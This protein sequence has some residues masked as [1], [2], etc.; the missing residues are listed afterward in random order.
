MSCSFT[1]SLAAT[2]SE[3]ITSNKFLS[4]SFSA[5]LAFALLTLSTSPLEGQI[6]YEEYFSEPNKGVE[7]PSGTFVPPTNLQWTISGDV[8]DLNNSSDYFKTVNGEL[9]ARDTEGDGSLC[10]ETTSINIAGYTDVR[11]SVDI[12]ETG[13]HENSDFVIV[14]YSLDNG[15]Y[16][17]IEDWDNAGSTGVTLDGNFDPSV[18]T[19]GG[20]GTGNFNGSS[21]LK[22]R[23]CVKNSSDSERF[24]IDNVIV[25]APEVNDDLV[26]ACPLKAVLI[27]DESGSIETSQLISTVRTGAQ[28]FVDALTASSTPGNESQLAVIE[29][30]SEARNVNVGGN[31]SGYQ[32]VDNGG[33]YA[34]DF[35]SYITSNG[36]G[37]YNPAG[38]S[39]DDR[40]T[41]W[42]DALQKVIDLNMYPDIVVFFTDGDPTAYNNG[43]GGVTISG[44]GLDDVA[45]ALSKAIPNANTIKQN[46]SHMFVLGV[47]GATEDNIV[48]ITGPDKDLGPGTPPPIEEADYSLVDIAEII[49]C[50]QAIPIEICG[51]ELTVSKSLSDPNPCANDP[52]TF[53]ITVADV[54][55][56]LDAVVVEVTDEIMS[57]YNFVSSVPAPSSQVGNTLSWDLGTLADGGSQVITISVTVNGE[58]NDHSNEVFASAANALQVSDKIF[59]AE[60]TIESDPQINCPNPLDVTCEDLFAAINPWVNSATGTGT[61]T[62]DGYATVQDIVDAV[63]ALAVGQTLNLTFRAATACGEVTCPTSITKISG[64]CTPVVECPNDTDLGTYDCNNFSSIPGEPGN[65][66]DLLNIYGINVTFCE[67]LLIDTYDSEEPNVCTTVTQNITRT[68]DIYDEADGMI[69]QGDTP[70]GTCTFTFTVNPNMAP[71][72]TPISN[73]TLANCNDPWPDVFFDWSDDCVAGGQAQATPGDV[74]DPSACFQ[75]RTYSVTVTDDCNVSTS[76]SVVVSRYYDVQGPMIEMIA[77]YTLDNCND[78]WPDVVPFDWTDNCGVGGQTSGTANATPGP[79]DDPTACFQSR[80]YTV[81][82]TDDCNNTSTKS[83]VV[84]RHYDVEG[85]MIEMIANYTLDNCNDP[86]PDVVPFD[87]TDNCGVNGQTSGTANATPGP[88]DDPTACFQ[89]RTYTVT[90]TDDCN[91]SSTKSVVVSRHYDVQGPMIEM[92]ANYTLDNCNDP[93]PDVVPFDWTDNCG[94]GGQTS[95][96][97]N[98]TPGDVDD[99]TACFQSRTYTV[100][101]TDDCNNTS[102]KSVVVSRHYDV[103]GPM[104]EMIANYTLDNCNDPWPDV[105]PFDWTDNCGVGGQ[106][107][108]TAKRYA[109]SSG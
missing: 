17:V 26:A 89:S 1:R 94:V 80:T 4:L 27:L 100:T 28:A 107:S 13:D 103:Q 54:A 70:I 12:R 39:G 97:A 10:F 46:G 19:A 82:V 79:V 43:S 66:T 44:T 20:H 98:A 95:G 85:P 84:S 63:D 58:N 76:A 88:V 34:G 96:T 36:A 23:I 68:I 35:D 102:T 57:G 22:I 83:V 15:P 109:W 30:N 11:F 93:W 92:I 51:T 52:V 18:V 9:S 64:C 31:G 99:P 14:S 5:S 2:I 50:L 53:T 87:W 45:E 48:E 37:G 49:P 29:F 74:D 59:D 60:V 25:I 65:A 104:I 90:V 6:L 75:S 72:I 108:G 41:N 62:V 33:S 8:S 105:V 101:V 81:T 73:Y 77:N 16:V 24:F 106:T 67:Q 7:G 86:W 38:Y 40:W 71:V 47:G 56:G 21:T 78:P 32:L 55:D 69:N 42:Q 91:N 3:R 61:I